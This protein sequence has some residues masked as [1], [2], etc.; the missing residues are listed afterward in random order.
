LISTQY[1]TCVTDG[2]LIYGLHGRDDQGQASLR[3]IDPDKQKILWQ[4]DDFGYATLL[5]ADGKLI[6]QKTDGVFVLA[7]ASPSQYAELASAQIFSTKTFALPALAAGRLY[8]RDERTLK[9]LDVRR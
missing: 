8:A 2:G 7:K 1:A 6:V 4:K 9:C 3:C 5:F